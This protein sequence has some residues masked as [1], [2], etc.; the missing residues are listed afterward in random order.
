MTTAELRDLLTSARP[1][2]VGFWDSF[3]RRSISPVCGCR[4]SLPIIPG[5]S[6]RRRAASVGVRRLRR[7]RWIGT[8]SAE[9]SRTATKRRQLDDGS[10]IRRRSL[11]TTGRC[12]LPRSC[13]CQYDRGG[14][15]P[16]SIFVPLNESAGMICCC[17]SEYG[18]RSMNR[19][20]S[21]ARSFSQVE[22]FE[23]RAAPYRAF[24]GKAERRCRTASARCYRERL[25]TRSPALRRSESDSQISNTQTLRRGGR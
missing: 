22:A 1:K 15:A 6:S 5:E 16:P 12:E 10:G 25:A 23:T 8:A 3:D 4:P 20:F 19:I 24:E 7:L 2:T 11:I 9:L 21:S 14:R 18:Y 17:D 13:L